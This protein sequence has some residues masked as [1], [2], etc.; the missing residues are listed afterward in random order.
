[1]RVPRIL[2]SAMIASLIALPSVAQTVEDSV[3]SQ[4]HS[5]GFS[6]VEVHRTW[7][8]RIR[9]EA[10]G[11]GMSREIVLN[12]RTGEILR[13]YW[14]NDDGGA[15][16]G[17]FSTG[18]T[19]GDDGGGGASVPSSSDDGGG[20]DASTDDSASDD[21]SSDDSGSTDDGGDSSSDDG[22]GGDD[23]G[24]DD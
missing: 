2:F 19:S 12:P 9:I 3:V 21:S 15:R 20:D 8:G 16:T 11:N 24:D 18:P 4:L 6:Q 23:G 14:H 1:M 10:S 17:I 5:Q 7:L 13:D 22:G